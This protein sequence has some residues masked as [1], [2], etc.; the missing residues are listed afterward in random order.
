MTPDLADNLW[1][2]AKFAVIAS[3]V[4][5]VFTLLLAARYEWRNK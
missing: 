3:V 2:I 4:W 5:L 1:R